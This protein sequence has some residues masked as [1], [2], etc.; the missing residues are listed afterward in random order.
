MFLQDLREEKRCRLA[1][2]QE[3]YLKIR[4][5]FEFFI[6][7]V[8]VIVLLPL[9]LLLAMLQKLN[10]PKEPVFFTQIRIG[11][12][13]Q[14][15]KIIKFRSL[16]STA[17]NSVATRDLANADLYLSGF[18]KFL[19]RTSLDELPQLFN[20]LR[21]E[22]SLIGPRPLVPNE[23]E[24]QFLRW[25][26]GIY[27]VRPGI[28]GWAQVNGRDFLDTYDKVYL[29]RDYVRKIGWKMDCKVLLMSVLVVLGRIGIHEG[30]I[31]E[32][33]QRES[34]ALVN[35]STPV[36]QDTYARPIGGTIETANL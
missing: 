4:R 16:K 26:Y 2:G 9:F 3:R 19:R 23:E 1:Q 30:R 34:I 36:Y 18:G 6:T 27:A 35:E 14:P 17:P 28:S 13:D 29:D 10:A 33:E 31:E 20:V 15:F 11:K 22:M 24:I 21:G 12:N 25:Y 7:L 5:G 8:T 32:G